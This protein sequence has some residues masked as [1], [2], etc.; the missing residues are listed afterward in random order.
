M[1]R[2]L[3]LLLDSMRFDHI[4]EEISPNLL[5]IA[6]D[7]IFYENCHSGGTATID[8][9]PVLLSGMREYDPEI[10][11]MT[12]LRNLGFWT[13]LVHS[14]PLVG[15]NFS[16]G[17]DNVIDL[18]ERDWG[19]RRV[20]LR[21]IL[22]KWVPH[23][24][25][26]LIRKLYRWLQ[27]EEGYIPY[28][29]AD[30]MLSAASNILQI[31]DT[32]KLFLWVHIMDPHIPYYPRDLPVLKNINN[33]QEIAIL[34]DKLVDAVHGRYEPSDEEVETYR[35]LYRMEVSEMDEAIGHF[36]DSIDLSDTIFIIT[37]DHG[38]EFGEEGQFSHHSN[39]F[40]PVLTHVP[41]IVVGAGKGRVS[42]PFSHYHF[43]K[44][45]MDVVT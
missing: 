28:S 24:A 12:Q 20:G 15:K 34:N 5:R 17:W 23:F 1:K 4:T 9:M 21:R 27:R 32:K 30:E 7:G 6:N 3:V 13:V 16:T 45:I 41:L 44:L 31:F 36:Y 35:L 37:A 19:Q 40:I 11:I 33:H 42:K 10:S 29:R 22:R 18:K 39:K 43:I 26:G 2:I 38:D 8:S 25:L 14:N